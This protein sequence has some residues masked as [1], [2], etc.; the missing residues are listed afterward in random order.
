MTFYGTLRKCRN[1]NGF[2]KFYMNLEDEVSYQMSKD[3][4]GKP[5]AAAVMKASWTCSMKFNEIDS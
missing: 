2:K 1:A 3:H 5:C 4:T